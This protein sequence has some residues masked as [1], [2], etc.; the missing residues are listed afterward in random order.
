MT[1]LNNLYLVG[2]PITSSTASSQFLNFLASSPTVIGLT[3]GVVMSQS[4][5]NQIN[6][7]TKIKLTPQ[8]DFLINKDYK[9]T[10]SESDIAADE[11]IVFMKDRWTPGKTGAEIAQDIVDEYTALNT[12][13][14][15][16]KIVF[17]TISSPNLW[18]DVSK[19][20]IP[21]VPAENVIDNPHAPDIAYNLLLDFDLIPDLPINITQPT[22]LSIETGKVN[23]IGLLSSK[24]A[25]LSSLEQILTD[26]P[27]ASIFKIFF[28]YSNEID[29]LTS[30]ELIKAIRDYR[31]SLQSAII[32]LVL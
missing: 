15:T 22:G 14:P 28:G 30:A 23:M 27:N 4:Q 19:N 1:T 6:S 2:L 5:M 9:F 25:D 32:S 11:K 26:N 16:S 7:G 13:Y 12:Q 17:F 21:L 8:W 24:T 20:L 3:A 10:I 31:H 18:N 29:Q